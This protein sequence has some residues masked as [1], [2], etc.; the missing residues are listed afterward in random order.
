VAVAR[1]FRSEHCPSLGNTLNLAI[2]GKEVYFFEG[3]DCDYDTVFYF[4]DGNVHRYDITATHNGDTTKYQNI[5]R[6]IIES[7]KFL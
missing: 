2:D 3:P 6:K 4:T 7:I 1:D 5:T